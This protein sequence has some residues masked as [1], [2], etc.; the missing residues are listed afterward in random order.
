MAG[1]VTL[2]VEEGALDFRAGRVRS[3]TVALAISGAVHGEPFVTHFT[4]PLS[5]VL[6]DTTCAPPLDDAAIRGFLAGTE[7]GAGADGARF[8]L[9][10][11]AILSG[12]AQ[13][14]D[15]PEIAAPAAALAGERQ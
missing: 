11:P 12:G 2:V 8:S 3:P 4:G 13:V 10:V 1:D 5:H 15:W 7:P 14:F 9:Q 6:R